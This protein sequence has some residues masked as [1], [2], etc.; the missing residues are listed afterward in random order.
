MGTWQWKRSGTG[1]PRNYVHIEKAVETTS[2]L[3]CLMTV[4]SNTLEVFR[5]YLTGM[6]AL[7]WELKRGKKIPSRGKSMWEGPEVGRTEFIAG[8]KRKLVW[9]QFKEWMDSGVAGS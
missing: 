9:V 7:G 4:L 1:L 5:E 8:I 2:E 3:N 6:S